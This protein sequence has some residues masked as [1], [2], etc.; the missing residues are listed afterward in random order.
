M[1]KPDLMCISQ[2][3]CVV[4]VPLDIFIPQGT[5]IVWGGGV[6]AIKV[7]I[8]LEPLR[9]PGRVWVRSGGAEWIFRILLLLLLFGHVCQS[10]QNSLSDHDPTP[11]FH[12]RAVP[13]NMSNTPSY[14]QGW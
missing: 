4:G 6:V 13:R 5:A 14:S 11:T 12:V 8:V 10:H 1:H 7:I 3:E 9:R 2:R